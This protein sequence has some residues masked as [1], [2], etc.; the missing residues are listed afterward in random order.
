MR[1][2]VLKR[3]I[4]VNRPITELDSL[5]G[6]TVTL[7]E[8][9]SFWAS[10]DRMSGSRSLQFESIG[11]NRPFDIVVREDVD[12]QEG[13]EITF[14]SMIL[15]VQSIERDYDKYRYKRIVADAREN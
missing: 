11:W 2:G 3:R 12:I 6:S 4:T 9:G 8:V 1:P 10:V 7:S 15:V 13:D 14:N 5:G